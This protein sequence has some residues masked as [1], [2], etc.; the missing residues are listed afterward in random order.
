MPERRLTPPIEFTT[1]KINKV[2]AVNW[3]GVNTLVVGL[4]MLNA[5]GSASEFWSIL[6]GNHRRN[7]LLGEVDLSISVAGSQSLISRHF[8]H[9]LVMGHNGVLGD[10]V[11]KRNLR[12]LPGI[13]DYQGWSRTPNGD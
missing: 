4:E 5:E 8:E 3:E 2:S 13:V 11:S 10:G 6:L 9:V 7:Y 1:P 12:W